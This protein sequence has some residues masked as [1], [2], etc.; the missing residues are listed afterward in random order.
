M[1]PLDRKKNECWK[2]KS[3]PVRIKLKRKRSRR[4]FLRPADG[5][6]GIGKRNLK[7]KQNIPKK[8]PENAI[9]CRMWLSELGGS[10]KTGKKQSVNEK[11]YPNQRTGQWRQGGGWSSPIIFHSK[12]TTNTPTSFTKA[13]AGGRVE[14]GHSDRTILITKI[15]RLKKKERN[16]WEILDNLT[17]KKEKNVLILCSLPQ[18]SNYFFLPWHKLFKEVHFDVKKQQWQKSSHS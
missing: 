3:L 14:G 9:K 8:N 12:T 13:L 6:W 5:G 4:A 18:V 2:K 1:F 17:S 15:P 11:K 10:R 7:P 16:N